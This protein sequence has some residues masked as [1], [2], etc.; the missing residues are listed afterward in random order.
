MCQALHSSTKRHFTESARLDLRSPESRQR[1]QPAWVSSQDLDTVAQLWRLQTPQGFFERHH[2]AH[3]PVHEILQMHTYEVM[4]EGRAGMHS[5]SIRH[6]V[7]WTVGCVR[8]GAPSCIATNRASKTRLH[9]CTSAA[10]SDGAGCLSS[11]SRASA[12]S[13]CIFPID[14]LH[15]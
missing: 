6:L 5:L 1:Q 2:A 14:C 15:C 3:C 7:S 11:L 10:C 8:R 9:I 12:S 13:S 4:Y